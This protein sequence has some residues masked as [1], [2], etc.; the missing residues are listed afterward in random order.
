M[1]TAAPVIPVCTS[2]SCTDGSLIKEVKEGLQ[3]YIMYCMQISLSLKLF[4]TLAYYA[5]SNSPQIY[6]GEKKTLKKDS[7]TPT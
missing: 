3:E 6:G 2:R 4:R 7:C 1:T 5:L